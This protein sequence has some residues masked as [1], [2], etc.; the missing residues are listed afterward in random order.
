M[1]ST[2]PPTRYRS[3]RPLAPVARPRRPTPGHRGDETGRVVAAA[4][5]VVVLALVAV[6]AYLVVARPGHKSAAPTTAAVA[7]PGLK[8]MVTGFI[9]QLG[10][11]PAS[12]R[13][14][15]SAFVVSVPWAT[16]QPKQGGPIAPDNPV[17][18][19]IAE[20][21]QIHDADPSENL[22]IVLRVEAGIDSPAWA[23]AIDGG[24]TGPVYNSKGAGAQKVAGTLPKFWTPQFGAAWSAFMGEL[25]AKYDGVAAIREA[26]VIDRC[27]TI[28]SEPLVRQTDPAS[29]HSLLA[30]GYTTAADETCQRQQI[31]EAKVWHHTYVSEN[32][33]PY[34]EFSSDGKTTKSISFAISMM[35]E[36]RDVLG[37]QCVLQNNEVGRRNSYP[38]LYAAMQQLGAPIA[39][40][41]ANAAQLRQGAGFSGAVT[42][43][44]DH[45]AN[46][47]EIEPAKYTGVA[48]AELAGFAARL[49]ADPKP[50]SG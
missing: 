2:R 30:A 13:P 28:F 10:L 26:N 12:E 16:L 17:D 3:P 42:F 5:L 7:P 1:R 24:P 29:V 43:A 8:P 9:D 31:E 46:A 48:G 20:V 40:Q 15:V 27:M 41:L 11:P 34:V 21:A 32:F 33:N 4:L 18:K 25:A 39:F 19:A 47:V 6:V 49:H 14:S 22:G 50:V 38:P 44:L 23:K 36:C 35:H 45:D 37:R